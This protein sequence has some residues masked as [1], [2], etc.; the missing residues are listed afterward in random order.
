MFRATTPQQAKEVNTNGATIVKVTNDAREFAKIMRQ[1]PKGAFLPGSGLLLS[2]EQNA[3][4]QRAD[5]L[6]NGMKG[7][8]TQSTGAGAPTGQEGAAFEAALDRGNFQTPEEHATALEEA[9]QSIERKF[10]DSTRA[11][12]NKGAEGETL[13]VQAAKRMGLKDEV[14]GA[15]KPKPDRAAYDKAIA[16][17]KAAGRNDLVKR[18]EAEMGAAN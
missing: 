8:L 10:Y 12:G 11:F 1:L 17:A 5:L 16:K 2:E 4:K 18:L 14:P 15:T 6:R 7:Q 3:L 13:R 9:A